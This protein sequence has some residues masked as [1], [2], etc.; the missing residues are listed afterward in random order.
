MRNRGEQL[1]SH[2]DSAMNAGSGRSGAP[3]SSPLTINQT[4]LKQATRTAVQAEREPSSLMARNI[5]L[6]ASTLE[7]RGHA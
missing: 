6:P 7:D 3:T 1:S 2:E 5:T 4:T